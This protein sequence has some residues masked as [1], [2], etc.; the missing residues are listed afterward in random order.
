MGRAPDPEGICPV[1]DKSTC[2]T[3]EVREA[4]DNGTMDWQPGADPC[5]MTTQR[6]CRVL[7]VRTL[8]RPVHLTDRFTAQIREDVTEYFRV[9]L[10]RRYGARFAIPAARLD[11]AAMPEASVRWRAFRGSDG[12]VAFAMSREI[13]HRILRYRYGIPESEPLEADTAGEERLVSILGAHFT[14]LIARR[15]ESLAPGTQPGANLEP[16][17]TPPG[18]ASRNDWTLRV[19]ID[20]ATANASGSLWLLLDEAWIARLLQ[21]LAPAREHTRAA[22]PESA[23]TP[24]LP[25]RL[26]LAIRAR[27]LEKQ[28]PLGAVL[29]LRIGDVIPVSL[30]R[31]DVLVEDSRLFTATVAEHKGKL[32]LTTFEDME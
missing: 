2:V 20:E 27:L 3:Q 12:I 6:T 15:I 16:V 5:R 14:N 21:A 28:M 31:A 18:L 7:D 24:P 9:H 13:V 1:P 8:G 29:D 26:Q 22:R 11:Y 25:I 23:S 30:G 10:N 4:G 17:E 19:D 32:C